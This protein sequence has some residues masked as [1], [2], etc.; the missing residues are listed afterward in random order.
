MMRDY[1]FD[2][3]FTSVALDFVCKSGDLGEVASE[4]NGDRLERALPCADIK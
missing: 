4:A 3:G 1:P 2:L